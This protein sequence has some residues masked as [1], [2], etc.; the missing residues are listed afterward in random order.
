MVILIH[1]FAPICHQNTDSR[2]N[3]AYSLL[4]DAATSERQAYA[5]MAS[6]L[7]DVGDGISVEAVQKLREELEKVCAAVLYTLG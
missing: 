4:R 2:E 3:G 6:A 5:T 7:E 1:V